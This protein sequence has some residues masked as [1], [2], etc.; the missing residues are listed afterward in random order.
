MHGYVRAPRNMHSH[1]G[2]SCTLRPRE[3]VKS[4]QLGAA[5]GDGGDG[6]TPRAP[7]NERVGM[8]AVSYGP[9][10]END[11]GWRRRKHTRTYV[12]SSLTTPFARPHAGRAGENVEMG[13]KDVILPSKSSVFT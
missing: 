6:S 2:M 7:A 10:T 9:V 12:D 11:G 5:A 1:S 3:P 13:E 8:S 4:P